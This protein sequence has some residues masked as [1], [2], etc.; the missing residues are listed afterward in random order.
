MVTKKQA[1]GRAASAC[2]GSLGRGRSP[3]PPGRQN[4]TN[5]RNTSVGSQ[6]G[7]PLPVLISTARTPLQHA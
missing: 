7:G 5:R 6:E 3:P 4:V 2:R 1:G